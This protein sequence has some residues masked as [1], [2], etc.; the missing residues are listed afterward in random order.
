MFGQYGKRVK[1]GGAEKKVGGGVKG[2][3]N[4]TVIAVAGC[5]GP[6]FVFSENFGD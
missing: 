1:R 2:A 4:D 3:Q 5:Q 6:H